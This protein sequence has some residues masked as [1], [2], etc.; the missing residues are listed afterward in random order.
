MRPTTLASAK[1]PKDAEV[2]GKLT[3][4]IDHGELFLHTKGGEGPTYR[5]RWA[6]ED[7]DRSRCVP[8]GSYIV[9]GYRH[10]AT[11]KDK[12]T[13]VWSTTSKGYAEL[14]VTKGETTHFAVHTK[15]QVRTRAVVRRG[16]H[17]VGLV[18]M[19]EKGLGNTLYR[20][21]KRIP[22]Q[23]QTLDADDEVLGEGTMR[24]G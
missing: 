3:S 12:A 20:N 5:L 11:A 9:S 14:E 16:K 18:F 13:W 22:I 15:L 7:K 10:V 17:R 19:A 8:V 4:T 1:P 23:W 6:P 21:G 2:T 24:Y